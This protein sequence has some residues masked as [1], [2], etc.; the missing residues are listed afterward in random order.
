MP[1]WDVS[2]A[3]QVVSAALGAKY[4]SYRC[5]QSNYCLFLRK[6]VRRRH[7]RTLQRN[8]D[9]NERELFHFCPESVIAKIW[10]EVLRRVSLVT[11]CMCTLPRVMRA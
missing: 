8:G 4:A 5:E 1:D 2:D 11:L 10:Q 6:L 9:P 3:L 7:Q